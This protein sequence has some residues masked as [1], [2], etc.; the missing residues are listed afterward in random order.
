MSTPQS[1][2]ASEDNKPVLGSQPFGSV[3]VDEY[4][5][6]VREGQVAN[7]GG[8]SNLGNN[9]KTRGSGDDVEMTM[10]STADT[11]NSNNVEVEDV[12]DDEGTKVM[13]ATK[14]QHTSTRKPLCPA[15]SM[16]KETRGEGEIC[17]QHPP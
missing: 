12:S 9:D 13:M 3:T 15:M 11:T 1:N 6:A 4:D 5:E 10:D 2:D 16:P 14:T 7:A 17:Q 8:S